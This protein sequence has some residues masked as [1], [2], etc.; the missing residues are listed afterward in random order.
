MFIVFNGLQAIKCNLLL[1]KKMATHVVNKKLHV[2][3]EFLCQNVDVY[4]TL[5]RLRGATVAQFSL[6]ETVLSSIATF[7]FWGSSLVK[8]RLFKINLN[9]IFWCKIYVFFSLSLPLFHSR[10]KT[11]TWATKI[12]QCCVEMPPPSCSRLHRHPR[13]MFANKLLTAAVNVTTPSTRDKHG[14]VHIRC[15]HARSI[16]MHMR[17]HR[18]EIVLGSTLQASNTT[19]Y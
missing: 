2:I 14:R 9:G 15:V 13:S 3:I 12:S 1:V 6:A 17:L 8:N 11:T 16:Q 19:R 4:E 10:K 18:P 5:V 7:N